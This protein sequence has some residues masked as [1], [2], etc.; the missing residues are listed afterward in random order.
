[1]QKLIEEPINCLKKCDPVSQVEVTF[2]WNLTT[3]V[4]YNQNYSIQK[5]AKMGTTS[6]EWWE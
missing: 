6:K 1:M 3:F 2:I 4:F 5:Y